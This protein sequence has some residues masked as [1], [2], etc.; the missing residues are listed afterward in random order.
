[1]STPPTLPPSPET[2]PVPTFQV[3]QKLGHS[4]Q[5]TITRRIGQ[6]GFGEVY[7]AYEERA[8][9][10]VAIKVMLPEHNGKPKMLRRFKGEYT[11]G[12]RL[13]HP[14]LVQMF[15][16]AI[17]PDGIHYIIM[18]FVDGAMLSTC[19]AQAEKANGQLGLSAAINL[20]FQLGNVL[21]Q[22]HDR[23][24]I[25]RDLKA[26]N[27]MVVKDT[28]VSGGLRYKLL[29]FGIAKLADQEKARALAVEFDT[30]TGAVMGTV[31]F[32][33]PETFL[34]QGKQGPES[35]V[36]ALSCILYRCIAGNYP[37]GGE[38]PSKTIL[39]H[40]SQ[41]PIPL[42]S[43]DPSTS[44]DVAN[45]IHRG[46]EK[47]PADRPTMAEITEFFA[48]QIGPSSLAGGQ[49]VVR[50]GTQEL[51][52][53]IG[54]ISTGA[55][56]ATKSA[57]LSLEIEESQRGAS[58][59]KVTT[60]KGKALPQRGLIVI[61]T[62]LAVATLLAAAAV[63]ARG[64]HVTQSHPVV[65]NPVQRAAQP[66]TVPSPSVPDLGGSLD[67]TTSKLAA[68]PDDKVPAP[69]K[70]RSKKKKNALLVHD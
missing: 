50:G 2:K 65:V 5:F 28:T 20:G 62:V 49:I 63:V 69:E 37:F 38:T 9:R 7:L 12:L 42:L 3:G 31:N 25:H 51:Q 41:P 8:E 59:Q 35:D 47:K 54:E 4:N 17:T 6:G 10:Y 23:Q 27:I 52:V 33:A 34:E 32:L 68:S 57:S 21:A 60:P 36:Y 40:I 64:L 14:N 48:R 15:D 11:L 16:L 44:P 13:N 26:S 46:L 19:M 56:P 67:A 1:M 58:S 29:D 24:L 43:E 45:I 70:K 55:Q 22:L 18:E 66:A 30:T 53:L 61:A 39:Q